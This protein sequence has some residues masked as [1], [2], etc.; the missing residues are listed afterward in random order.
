M[1]SFT[2]V[3][4]LASA[5]LHAH[6]QDFSDLVG[7]WSSKSNSTFTGDGFYNPSADHFTEPKHP[8]IS[9]SFS[10]DGYY[11]E[12]YYRAVAN[13]TNP[14][15]PRGIIQ[16][17]HGKFEKLANGSLNLHP[18]RVDGRQL[19]SDPCVYKNSIYTR[20]NASETFTRYESRTDD[21]HKIPRLNL[22]KF[23]GSPL[24]PLYLAFSTPKM[25]PTTTLNPLVTA[26]ATAKAKARRALPM[27]DE[28]LLRKSGNLADGVFWAGVLASGAGGLLW[29]FF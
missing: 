22:Y 6:A 4:L 18:I 14:K 28:V 13:P 12:S 27:P 3:L 1:V 15:C 24:M 10:A 2:A 20:Y 5:A 25:L 21:Y 17:Q 11:E 26:T 23:D 7:T 19:Y 16:W 8:G 9:Y 29:W